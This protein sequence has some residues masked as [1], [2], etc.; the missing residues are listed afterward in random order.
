MLLLLA[1]AVPLKV[2]FAFVKFAARAKTVTGT[3]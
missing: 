1:L 3:M 2:P